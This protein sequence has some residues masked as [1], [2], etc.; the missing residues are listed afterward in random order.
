MLFTII[1]ALLFALLFYLLGPWIHRLRNRLK[2]DD[3]SARLVNVGLTMVAK[4]LGGPYTTQMQASIFNPTE[5]DI[6]IKSASIVKLDGSL[7]HVVL[8]SSVLRRK[9]FT[10]HFEIEDSDLPNTFGHTPGRWFNAIFKV[11]FVWLPGES[12][13]VDSDGETQLCSSPWFRRAIRWSLKK[14]PGT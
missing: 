7:R 14:F 9:G 5:R 6:E 3:D 1:L 13:Y 11:T 12:W 8:I 2:V 10:Q 4:Q